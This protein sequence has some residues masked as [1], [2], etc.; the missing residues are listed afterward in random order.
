MC[1]ACVWLISTQI[2]TETHTHLTP[3]SPSLSLSLSRFL[4]V[5][6]CP[7]R[8]LG[9]DAS[10]LPILIGCVYHRC[11]VTRGFG[12]VF[13]GRFCGDDFFVAP[14]PPLPQRTASKTR[15]SQCT[16][17][18]TKKNLPPPPGADMEKK[19]LVPCGFL[20]YTFITCLLQK[21][22]WWPAIVSMTC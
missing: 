13:R 19:L 17:G 20:R 8:I 10:Q 11:K 21:P 7:C 4:C 12:S 16:Q 3:V 2:E 18:K 15:L 9:A 6:H 5:L 14:T 22:C 1:Y